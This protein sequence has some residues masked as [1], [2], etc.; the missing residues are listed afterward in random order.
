MEFGTLEIFNSW[1]EKIH[2]SSAIDTRD[3]NGMQNDREAQIG[4]YTYIFN[5]KKKGDNEVKVASGN[6][7]LMR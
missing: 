4:V 3:W 6:V 5:Y 1:G 2:T 7:S